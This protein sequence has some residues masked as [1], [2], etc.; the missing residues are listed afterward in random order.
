MASAIAGVYF[1][2]SEIMQLLINVLALSSFIV[3]GA[4]VGSGYYIY[5]NKEAIID[6][7]KAQVME[8]VTGGL[9]PDI[10]VLGGADLPITGDSVIPDGVI[11]APASIPTIPSFN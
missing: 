9:M 2:F 6:T 8:E 11:A 1:Y 10:P 3:S 5:S 7:V 4:I